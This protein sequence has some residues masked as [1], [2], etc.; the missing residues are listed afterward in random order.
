ME[1]IPI[2]PGDHIGYFSHTHY[3]HAIYCGDIS[4][5]NRQ[6]KQVVIHYEGKNKRGQIRGLAFHKFAQ[7]REIYIFPYKKNACF[8]PETVIERAISKLGEPEYNLFGNNCEHFAHWCKTGKTISGQVNNVIYLLGNLGGGVLTGAFLPLG[9]P[10]IVGMG[11][12]MAVGCTSGHLATELL[13]GST[14]YDLE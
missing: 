5:R 11:I 14:D 1:S 6:Y 7:N 3:H 4:Y 10:V 8:A 2:Q 13:M 9:V 12:A